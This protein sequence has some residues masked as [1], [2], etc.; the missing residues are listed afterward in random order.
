MSEENEVRDPAALLAAYNTL[1]ADMKAT[2]EERDSLKKQVQ[3]LSKDEFRL[4]ALTAEAKLALAQQGIKDERAFKLVGTE[5]LDFGEDGSV[6]GLKERVAE[7]T[8][9]W[10]EVF[11]AKRR[12]G[13]KADIHAKDNAEVKEDPMRSAVQ[14]AL[15]A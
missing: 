3:S 13:G 11:D 15:S 8:K 1:K 6:T 9:E 10:P 2:A 14:S 7:L 12:A 5:G 4:K